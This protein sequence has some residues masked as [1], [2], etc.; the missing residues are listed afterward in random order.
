MINVIKLIMKSPLRLGFRAWF[1]FR[2]GWS[3]YFTFILAAANTTVTTYYLAVKQAPDLLAIFPTFSHYLVIIASVGI[4]LLIIIGYVHFKKSPA[5]STEADISVESNP[6]NYKLYPGWTIEVI[7]PLY[8]AL[9]EMMIKSSK[10]EKLT[11][12]EIKKLSELQQKINLL[13]EGGFVGEPPRFRGSIH[14]K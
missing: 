13:I 8:K 10:D 1:Y 4:P 5:Y 12:D 2:Q 11:D 7:F 14:S 6:Y 9:T 3:A